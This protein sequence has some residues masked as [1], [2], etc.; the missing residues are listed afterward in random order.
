MITFALQ[1]ERL[2]ELALLGWQRHLTH[3]G[4]LQHVV[5]VDLRVGA[6]GEFNSQTLTH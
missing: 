2:S 5:V 3:E 4:V 1:V 6:R